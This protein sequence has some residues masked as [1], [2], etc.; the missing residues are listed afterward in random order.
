MPRKRKTG[1]PPKP[2]DSKKPSKGSAVKG[3]RRAIEKTKPP[4]TKPTISSK[5]DTARN[6]GVASRIRNLEITQD[7]TTWIRQGFSSYST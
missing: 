4:K 5:T 3:V 1:G 6:K 2:K 7:I